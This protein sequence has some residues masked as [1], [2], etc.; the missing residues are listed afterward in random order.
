MEFSPPCFSQPLALRPSDSSRGDSSRDRP[1]ASGRLF[2]C[3]RQRFDRWQFAYE[4]FVVGQGGFDLGLLKHDLGDPHVIRIVGDT[5]GQR[6]LVLLKPA[7]P[8]PRSLLQGECG[9][10][11]LHFLLDLLDLDEVSRIEGK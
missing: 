6:P 8:V 2:V 4:T 10:G 1:T 9:G 7:R 3:S 11:F 5:P